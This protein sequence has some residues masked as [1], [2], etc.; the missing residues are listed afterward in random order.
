MLNSPG[1]HYRDD[2][3]NELRDDAA[4]ELDMFAAWEA[5]LGLKI[6]SA[7]APVTVFVIDQ[8][9]RQAAN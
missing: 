6:E 8:V 2:V 3:A 9:A 1:V 5:Q 4:N 7:K